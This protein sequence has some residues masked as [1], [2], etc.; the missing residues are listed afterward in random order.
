M[1]L[2]LFQRTNRKYTTI[3]QDLETILEFNEK[4]LLKKF[5]HSLCCN[6][7]IKEHKEFGK[8][9]Q[10]QGDKRNEIRDILMSIYKI[11]E[12]QIEMHGC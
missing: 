2:R 5:K 3:I 9:F 4:D 7:S 8:I 11:K 10:L 12:D 1:H 6:G